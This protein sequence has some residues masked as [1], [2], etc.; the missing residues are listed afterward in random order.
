WMAYRSSAEEPWPEPVRVDELS[1]V[2]DEGAPRVSADGLTIYF[3]SDR[4]GVGS[5]DIYR[6]VRAHRSLA[7][8]APELVT[9][10]NGE[11]AESL[12]AVDESGLNAVFTRLDPGLALNSLDIFVSHRHLPGERW[13]VPEPAV[14]LNTDQFGEAPGSLSADGLTLYFYSNAD[15][16]PVNLYAARR[17]TADDPFGEPWPLVEVSTDGRD[18]DPFVTPDGRA[19]YFARDGDLYRAERDQ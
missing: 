3:S 1:T 6:S 14:E 19:L 17:P 9:T 15:G 7:W 12:F 8:D 16:G 18:E 2:H 5:V 11:R 10:V 4:P 13:S